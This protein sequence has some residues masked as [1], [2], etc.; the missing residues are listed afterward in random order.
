MD[1]DDE[2]EEENFLDIPLSSDGLPKKLL[3]YTRLLEQKVKSQDDEIARLLDL[4]DHALQQVEDQIEQITSLHTVRNAALDSE[5]KI[6]EENN[7]LRLDVDTRTREIVTLK[8]K[9]QDTESALQDADVKIKQRDQEVSEVSHRVETQL[10]TALHRT[11]RAHAAALREAR[12]QRDECSRLLDTIA[13]IIHPNLQS[14][15][16]GHEYLIGHCHE[17]IRTIENQDIKINDLHRLC[18]EYE[19]QVE[20]SKHVVKVAEEALESTEAA[21]EDIEQNVSQ[22]TIVDDDQ[23]PGRNE[24]I[25]SNNSLDMSVLLETDQCKPIPMEEKFKGAVKRI[26]RM[27][28]KLREK[29]VLLR[30]TQH[31]VETLEKK[32]EVKQIKIRELG[33]R[34]E[35][36]EKLL[37]QKT[38]DNEDME[39]KYG[40]LLRDLKFQIQNGHP[41]DKKNYQELE[42]QQ[43]QPHSNYYDTP[44]PRRGDTELR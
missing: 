27:E 13:S 16:P 34:V 44:Y 23:S 6:A 24:T 7:K 35:S 8:L 28:V 22:T 41:E 38:K 10:K 40:K 21:T 18:E 4:R 36:L 32:N 26:K 9:V 5:K 2:N 30:K 25:K 39:S 14:K 11:E 33:A 20:E 42:Y 31:N 37:K 17:I 19:R 12:E 1:N 3:Q 43:L 15:A 29:D